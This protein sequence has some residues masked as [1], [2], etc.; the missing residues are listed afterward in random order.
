MSNKVSQLLKW[1]LQSCLIIV[2]CLCVVCLS[3]S[4][5]LK[6]P[7]ITFKFL[8][9]SRFK[10]VS[11]CACCC[12][13]F[14]QKTEN[15]VGKKLKIKR[16]HH[17][18]RQTNIRL[19]LDLCH[20]TTAIPCHTMAN[21]SSIHPFNLFRLVKPEVIWKLKLFNLGL[22]K[23][24]NLSLKIQQQNKRKKKHKNKNNETKHNKKWINK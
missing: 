8:C 15:S 11:V 14:G 22:H 16:E 4:I 2:V 6:Y 17:C 13:H 12:L 7:K 19:L 18:I 5:K 23:S 10:C 24:Q 1:R 3:F 21:H 9:I 20:T